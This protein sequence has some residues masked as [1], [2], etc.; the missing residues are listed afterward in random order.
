MYEDIRTIEEF[1]KEAKLKPFDIIRQVAKNNFFDFIHGSLQENCLS[2]R[3][4]HAD[5]QFKSKGKIYDA[6]LKIIKTKGK[7]RLEQEDVWR[8]KYIGPEK[9]NGKIIKESCLKADLIE[10]ICVGGCFSSGGGKGMTK[11]REIYRSEGTPEW[12]L[13]D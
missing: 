2:D 10:E 8:Y 5:F 4:Y 3:E 1:I 6:F 11:R 7:T 9:T 12:F 13:E